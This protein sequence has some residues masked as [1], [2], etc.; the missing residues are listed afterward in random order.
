MILGVFVN[1]EYGF[2]LVDAGRHTEADAVFARMKTEA[3]PPTRARG[4]RSTALLQM[5]RGKYS[6][7][8]AE[9]RQA[10]A[11][12]QTHRSPVSEYRDRFILYSA[13]HAM[14]QPREAALEWP[15]SRG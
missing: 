15:R 6:A 2:T 7:A 12:N 13:L 10:I 4:F 5:Y 3:R 9:L 1:H 14:G 11:L 8:V